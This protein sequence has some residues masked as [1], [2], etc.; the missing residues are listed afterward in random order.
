MSD[1][2][3]YK[4]L[5][6]E[7][8]KIDV[9]RMPPEPI[10]RFATGI[11][12]IDSA[13]HGGIPEGKFIE[14]FGEKNS[15]KTTTAM[16]IARQYN[17]VG[18]Y[19][20]WLDA[21]KSL[22]PE[23]AAKFGWDVYE[24]N[25]GRQLLD[26][27]QTETAEQWLEGLRKILKSNLYDL[28]V[29]DSLAAFVPRV[30]LESD[31]EKG[32]M[33]VFP[34][35]VSRFFR[36]VGPIMAMGCK[37]TVLILNQQRLDI[38]NANIYTGAPKIGPG[39]QAKDHYAAVTLMTMPPK[40]LMDGTERRGIIQRYQIKKSKVFSFT[41]RKQYELHIVVDEALGVYEV[42]TSY[43]LFIVAQEHGLFK[44]EDGNKWENRVAYFNGQKIGNGEKQILAFLDEPSDLRQQ[45]VDT[46]YAN[47]S[48]TGEVHDLPVDDQP[49]VGQDE[50]P[51]T[52]TDQ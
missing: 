13:F 46:L 30:E 6:S 12:S 43:E 9:K 27:I 17:Q 47:L 41:P 29:I 2:K 34:R 7:L 50:S 19:V 21:E 44:D 51:D 26:V 20:C 35:L 45:I 36:T 3:Q 49:G 40:D 23:Y 10:K 42:D 25:E 37:T 18:K 4:S 48:K 28:V 14:M 1:T 11:L 5:M 33:G 24:Q 38:G 31:L 52:Q 22:D 16:L 32:I 39:G 8:D 15:G